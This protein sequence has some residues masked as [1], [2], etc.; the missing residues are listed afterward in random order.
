MI[1]ARTDL[2]RVQLNYKLTDWSN[3]KGPEKDAVCQGYID[4]MAS[5]Q[6]VQLKPGSYHWTVMPNYSIKGDKLVVLISAEVEEIE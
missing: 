5:Q 4:Q 6:F 1:M 3:M 2:F